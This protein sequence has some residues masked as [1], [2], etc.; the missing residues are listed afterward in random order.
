MSMDI[1]QF[2]LF[3]DSGF[4][5]LNYANCIENITFVNVITSHL[6]RKRVRLGH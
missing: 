2:D 3:S 5:R 6:R 4:F 1:C